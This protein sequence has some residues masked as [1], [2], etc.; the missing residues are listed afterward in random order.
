MKLPRIVTLLGYAGLI[1]FLA[2]PLWLSVAADQAPAW[3]DDAWRI[4]VAMIASFM[5]GTFWGFA[6][7]AC[8]GP[9]G[10]I[11]LIAASLLLILAWIA[12]ILPST[13]ALPGL[14][15][16][17]LLQLLADFWRERTLGSVEGYF[18]LRAVLTVGAC[19][20]I[21]WRLTIS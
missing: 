11:G 5:S 12:A 8:E 13:A 20:A 19:V 15:A 17:F 9:E 2:G 14:M 7:P 3:V 10:T 18:Q 4:Y 1:P 6:L 21:G 16:V